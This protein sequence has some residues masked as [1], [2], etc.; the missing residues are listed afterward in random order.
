MHRVVRVFAA[1]I[2]VSWGAAGT[3][4]QPRTFELDDL[5]RLVRLSDPQIAPDGKTVA[6]VVA[7]ADLDANRWDSQLALVDVASGAIRPMTHDRRGV[8]RP[9]WSPGGRSLAFLARAGES[10]DGHT[11][12]F[13]MPLAGGEAHAI[14]KSPTDV[15]QFAWSPDGS[16][17]AFAA[18]DE[19]PRKSGRERFDDAFEVGNDDVL[20]TS[21]PLPSH[22]WVIPV[23][24]GPSRLESFPQFSPDGSQIAYWYSRNGDINSENDVY[25]V[26][27]AGGTGRCVTQALDRSVFRLLWLPD[28]KS[29]LV[30]ANDVQRTSLWVQTLDGPSRRLDTGRVSVQSAFW[31]E[32]TTGA[33]GAIAFVGS[34]PDKPAEVYFMDSIGGAPR[35]LTHVNRE[36]AS[37]NFK[38]YHALKDNG[39]ET[40]FVAYPIPG[41]S[42]ADPLR[43]RDV[44]R[45]WIEWVEQH[46]NAKASSQ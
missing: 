40:K 7:K 45:R 2:V 23:G 13:E 30:A 6:I 29:M 20:T 44:Q 27:A 17:F 41:H 1:A 24:G 9:R 19:P 26:S 35:A 46:F 28:G 4:A 14:T 10:V 38:L 37:L 32:V 18:E 3:F 31:A 42:A 5:A 36:V 11:Q 43:Q 21:A 15:Q 8:G 22:A 34:E 39:V 33:N 12:I 16:Q 25:V